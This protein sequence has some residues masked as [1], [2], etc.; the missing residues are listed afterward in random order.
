MKRFRRCLILAFVIFFV[1][2]MPFSIVQGANPVIVRNQATMTKPYETGDTDYYVSGG[3][4]KHNEKYSTTEGIIY[5]RAFA[6]QTSN[7]WANA[8]IED[9]FEIIHASN[10]RITFSFNYKGSIE[11][12][13]FDIDP[14]FYDE[15]SVRVDLKVFLIDGNDGSIV[16]QKIQNIY[17]GQYSILNQPP[18]LPVGLTNS[19]D[20]VLTQS[21]SET[22]IYDWR[23]E[24]RT[25][26]SSTDRA[27]TD[28]E[29]TA[30]F[31]NSDY[32]AS[33]TQVR[34][35]DLSPDNT[36]PITSYTLSGTEGEDNW[37]TSNVIVELT[38]TDA[39]YGVENTTYIINEESPVLYISPFTISSEGTNTIEYYSFD[40]ANNKENPKTLDVNIDTTQPTG[41]LTI[42]D[43][44]EYT[45]SEEVMLNVTADDGEG[46]DLYQ[47]RF[48]NEGDS[49]IDSWIDYTA[50]PTPWTLKTGD[51][52]KRVYAQ[53]KDNAG[54]ISPQISDII[55][56]DTEPPTTT[57][58]LS[59][60]EG[61]A[62]WYTS[63]VIVTLNATDIGSE[64]DYIS[65][66]V[67]GASWNNYSTPITIGTEDTNILEYYSVD[68][69]NNHEIAEMEEIKIDKTRPTGGIT[70]NSGDIYTT[71]TSVT[72]S[73]TYADTVSEVDK[74]RY[75]N[76]AILDSQPWEDPSTTKEWN[77]R[78]GEGTKTVYYQ[79]KDKA[80]N[81][82]PL[83]SDSIILDTDPP[84]A[85]VEI[86]EGD[87]YTNSTS[88]ILYLQYS[89]NLGVTQVRY[90]NYGSAYTE[91]EQPTDTKNWTLSSGDGNKTVYTQFKDKAGLTSEITDTIVLDTTPPT[92]SIKIN[93][94]DSDTKSII[95]IVTPTADDANGVT[96]MRLKNEGEDWNDWEEV[97]AKNWTLTSG[98]GTKT[99]FAQFKDSA[100]STSTIYSATI[101][102]VETD[103]PTPTPSASSSPSETGNVIIYVNDE[104]NTLIFGATVT[105][106]TQP[107]GQ[108]ILKGTTDSQGKITFNNII[109]GSYSFHA[110]KDNL[111]SNIVQVTVE[112]Q[113]TTT[114]N[115]SL[116]E[117]LI[118]PT[119]SVEIAPENS[120]SSQIVFSVT[121]A[122]DIQGSGIASI[123][124]YIDEEPA[125]TWTTEGTHIYDEGVYSNGTHTY[126]VEAT[127][128]AGNT[129]RN[130]E[131]GYLQFSVDEKANIELEMWKIL[132][133]ALVLANGTALVLLAAK[134]KK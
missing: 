18:S 37:Y 131:S 57:S 118:K 103:L 80:G 133:L 98:L 130:P 54:N 9:D 15:A 41:Q 124:L 26:V 97:T 34:V 93:N 87:E 71:S 108:P 114:A 63:N 81:I 121:A 6:S 125:K 38:A 35:V 66:R 82:S 78:P 110:S 29:V 25:E 106:S 85:A 16:S 14:P 67:N 59:G 127:D 68:K 100:G 122:D 42:N 49:W 39:G 75:G 119:I 28:L 90:R 107:T 76:D 1:I 7:A 56:L 47:M 4:A 74:I 45:D 73:L 24:L 83:E 69:A 33:V 89:D 19:I 55:I 102:L 22:H 112:S 11:I 40:K 123:T 88:V 31:Y 2:M 72:L 65:Y 132:G 104:N 21:L 12:T 17:Q 109:V 58:S 20:V 52:N 113:Q 10:Y 53:F 23:A 116:I 134:R 30:D 70:I 46:S 51:G 95:V 99:V 84:L 62:N 128:N 44:D 61:E 79:I 50:E 129:I 8:S 5:A 64:V 92:G 117:D 126:Y 77:L 115:I 94:G 36:A 91:W 111:G 86:N 27:G 96:Q 13:G 105:S 120:G 43:D 48:R 101:N 3:Q 60:T 32:G